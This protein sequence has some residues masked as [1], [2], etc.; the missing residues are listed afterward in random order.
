ME[1]STCEQQ[2]YRPVDPPEKRK[3]QKSQKSGTPI[4]DCLRIESSVCFKILYAETYTAVWGVTG[5]KWHPHL[6]I[7]CHAA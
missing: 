1:Y 4:L 2:Q 6:Q 5:L 3:M 7:R